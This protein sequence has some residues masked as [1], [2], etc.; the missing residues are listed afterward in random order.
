MLDLRVANKLMPLNV[1]ELKNLNLLLTLIKSTSSMNRIYILDIPGSN[2]SGDEWEWKI[3]ITFSKDKTFSVGAR[4]FSRRSSIQNIPT[5]SSLKDGEEVKEALKD[6]LEDINFMDF[7]YDEDDRFEALE[8][9]ISAIVSYNT[10]LST[11]YNNL[12]F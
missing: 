2:M 6:L 1:K 3:F 12:N 7:L 5:I 4:M 9:C 11:P 8:S 10:S